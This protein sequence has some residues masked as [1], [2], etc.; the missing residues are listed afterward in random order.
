MA[1]IPNITFGNHTA[2]NGGKSDWAAITPKIL[3]KNTKTM[4]IQIPKARF[5]PIPPRRFIDE[6]AT[7]I[8]V[9]IK[10]ETGKLHFLYSTNS[11][12][13]IFEEPRCFSFSIKLFKFP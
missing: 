5:T 7:A 11:Y 1:K 2:T 12:L 3:S 8:M 9:N 6:T 4:A 10:T 13:P